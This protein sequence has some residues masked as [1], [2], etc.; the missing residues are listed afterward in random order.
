MFITDAREYNARMTDLAE[1][2][3]TTSP[4]LEVEP[5]E[6][7]P[8]H[9]ITRVFGAKGLER[10]FLQEVDALEHLADEQ[11][12]QITDA[13]EIAQDAHKHDKR[14]PHPYSTHFLRVATR[15][16]YYL[17]VGDPDIIT[18]ALLHD[19]VE[20]HPKYLVRGS[21]I[22]PSTFDSHEALT[23]AAVGFLGRRFNPRV[24]RLVSSVTNPKFDPSKDR[25]RQYRHHVEHNLVRDREARIIKLADFIENCNGIR[26]AE[27]IGRAKRSAQKYGPLI[28]VMHRLSQAQD[29][30]LCDSARTYMDER[31]WRG[32]ELCI[33]VLTGQYV[34]HDDGS[35]EILD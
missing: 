32:A 21:D 6:I 9:E 17:Q 10:R 14:G 29:T 15:V 3:R 18:A 28:P 27:N 12:Q 24:S 1:Q 11:Q 8:L 16:I 26:H 5:L 7:M 2:L 20:D 19:T 13:L 35:F 23:E 30:P 25:N 33:K 34:E 4:E 22:D 31:L